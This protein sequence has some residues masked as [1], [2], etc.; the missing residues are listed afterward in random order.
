M[1][2]TVASA[3]PFKPAP[4]I[5]TESQDFDEEIYDDTVAVTGDNAEDDQDIYDD[6]IGVQNEM[7]V[8]V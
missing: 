1:L 3:R 6:T 7:Y 8:I 5:P 2:F 4:L